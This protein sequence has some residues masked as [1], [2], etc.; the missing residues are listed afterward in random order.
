MFKIYDQKSSL[1]FPNGKTYTSEEL[2]TNPSYDILFKD[3]FI[4]ENDGNITISFLSLNQAKQAFNIESDDPETILSE[5]SAKV[6]ESRK[7]IEEYKTDYEMVNAKA[8]ENTQAIAEL[9]V[10]TAEG[11]ASNADVLQALGELGVQVAELS[12]KVDALQA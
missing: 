9:G 10:M 11:Q 12:A 4:I 5:Y 7:K 3:T 6:E 2:K 1:T 8:D